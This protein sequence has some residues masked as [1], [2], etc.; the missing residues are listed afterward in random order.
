MSPARLVA[1]RSAVVQASLDRV[2]ADLGQQVRGARQARKWTTRVLALRAGVSRGAVYLVERGEPTSLEVAIRCLGALGLRMDVEAVD[3]RKRHQLAKRTEDPVHSAMG[4]LEAKRLRELGYSVAIDEP[5]QHYQFA[6]R[7]DL[8]A[9][10]IDPPRILH[11]ENRTQFPNFQEAAGS[12]NA[13]RAY[14]APILAE[15]FGLRRL[16][17]VTHVMACLWSSEV[18][19]AIRQ[20][21]ETFRSLAPDSATAFERWWSGASPAA[22]TTSTLIVLDPLAHGRERL[23]IGLDAALAVARPRYRGYADAATGMAANAI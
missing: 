16:A 7:A 6:G 12:Y 22:G 20:R 5:Y 1:P 15:R 18:L 2:W 23:W 11:V 9:W 4:E 3:P 10:A 21:P 19:H 8:V 17:S 14:L 13:K